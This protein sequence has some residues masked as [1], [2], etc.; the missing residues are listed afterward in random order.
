MVKKKLIILGFI[1]FLFSKNTHALEPIQ[2]YAG[3][4]NLP[5]SQSDK[6]SEIEFTA[7]RRVF[8]IQGIP[9]RELDN[10][11]NI[12]KYQTIFTSGSLLDKD[13][14]PEII[15]LLYDYVES[16]GVLFSA[17]QIGKRFYSLFGVN[18]YFPSRT[19]Y[20]LHFTPK[21][22]ALKYINRPEELTISLGNGQGH[23]FD[24]VIW[25][26]GYQGARGSRQLGEFDDGRGAFF[27]HQYGRGRKSVV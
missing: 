6:N 10:P 7:L 20:R 4:L 22:T 24:E 3:L 9:Y 16:G 25:T 11:S 14:T 27:Y 2:I 23:F 5:S 17:G 18:K 12:F 13:T 1:F 8:D 15:N 21:I 26:H 19:R